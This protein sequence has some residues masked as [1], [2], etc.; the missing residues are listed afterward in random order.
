MEANIRSFKPS[1][2]A[3]YPTSRTAVW[4][5]LSRWSSR[6]KAGVRSMK[7]L[8][9]LREQKGRHFDPALVDLFIEQMPA[10]RTVQQR[11]AE[12]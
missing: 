11:W 3:T 2:A 7:A 8:N 12:A 9:F 6:R 1:G 10:V 5:A 4:S